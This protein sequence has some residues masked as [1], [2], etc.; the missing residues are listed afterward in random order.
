MGNERTLKLAEWGGSASGLAGAAI[1]CLNLPISG[2]GFAAFL[3]SNIC[4]TY[5]ALRTKT[6]GML[7]MQAGFMATS[8]TGIARWL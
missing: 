7:L 5:F 2:V 1:L 6:H 4:W 3:V 8:I